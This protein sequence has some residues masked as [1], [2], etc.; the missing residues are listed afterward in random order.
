MEAKKSPEADLEKRK[1]SFMLVG[2]LTAL[3]VTLVAF[4]WTA[5]EDKIEDM[6]ALQ[7]D[8]LEE[9]VDRKSVV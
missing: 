1:S 8:F 5:F 3:A 6:G 2:V 4:E 7:L 9:E